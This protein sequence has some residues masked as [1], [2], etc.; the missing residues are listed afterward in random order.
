MVLVGNRG[1]KQGSSKTLGPISNRSDYGHT[2]RQILLSF[3]I[4]RHCSLHKDRAIKG[5]TEKNEKNS[6]FFTQNF[7]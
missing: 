5:G 2:D 3:L 7:K 4:S 6:I 1:I